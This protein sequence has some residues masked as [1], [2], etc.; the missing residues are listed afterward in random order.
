MLNAENHF[1]EVCNST[2]LKNV[3]EWVQIVSLFLSQNMVN[4]LNYVKTVIKCPVLLNRMKSSSHV[5]DL[6]TSDV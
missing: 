6:Q 2:M 4:R 3:T 1:T 5:P